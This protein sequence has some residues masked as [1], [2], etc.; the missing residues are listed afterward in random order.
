ATLRTV[1]T[2]DL[3]AVDTANSSVTGTES[4]ITVRPGAAASLAMTAIPSPETAGVAFSFQG[5]AYDACGNGATGYAGTVGFSSTLPRAQL[6]GSY[7]FTAADGGRH[8]FSVTVLGAGT[9]RVMVTDAANS[10]LVVAQVGIQI[11]AS[12]AASLAV[13]GY[14]SPIGAGMA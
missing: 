11:Q 4:R 2:Q 13:G 8:T 14:P 12:A 6:P 10:N 7:T 3:R 5:T 9:G 1:G